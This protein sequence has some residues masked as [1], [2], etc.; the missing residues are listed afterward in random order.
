MREGF[1]EVGNNRP[2]M[3]GHCMGSVGAPRTNI[4]ACFLGLVRAF[5]S[6]IHLGRSMVA[7]VYDSRSNLEV[8]GLMI[9]THPS[10]SQ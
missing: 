2:Q 6:S 7:K 3:V 4:V 5:K 1:V 8:R 9:L 10:A